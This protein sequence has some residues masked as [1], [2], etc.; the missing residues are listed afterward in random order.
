MDKLRNVVIG[1]PNIILVIAGLFVVVLLLGGTFLLAKNLYQKDEPIP[2]TTVPNTN[3]NTLQQQMPQLTN[4][5]A[6]DLS[7]QIE[8]AKEQQ[9]PQYH[10]YTYTQADADSKAQEY[11][12]RQKADQIVK[13]TEYVPIYVNGSPANSNGSGSTTTTTPKKTT[14]VMDKNGKVLE[15]ELV[16]TEQQETAQGQ[17]IEN[18]YYAINLNR[19][20]SVE[21][22]V[23]YVD[24]KVYAAVSYRNRDV[25]YEVMY[26]PKDRTWGAGVMVTVAKW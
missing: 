3:P 7:H 25:R 10:Y 20:H 24:K 17:I 9:A 5:D 15:G 13:T 26:S 22:G 4:S 8:R 21:A 6:Q 16:S 23:K 1:N 11:A 14:T 18:S 19:K 12:A 2:I